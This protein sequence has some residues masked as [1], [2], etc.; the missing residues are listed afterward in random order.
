M[1]S[2]KAKELI[3]SLITDAAWSVGVTSPN[4]KSKTDLEAYIEGLEVM[5][6]FVGYLLDNCEREV[7]YEESLQYWLSEMLRK[8]KEKS[9]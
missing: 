3:S 4:L 5:E 8:E 6:R 2:T 9:E 7:I 1:I